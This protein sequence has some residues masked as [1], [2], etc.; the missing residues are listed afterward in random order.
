MMSSQS[1]VTD[2]PTTPPPSPAPA[3]PDAPMQQLLLTM[4]AV[5]AFV[6]RHEDTPGF[7][8]KGV[9]DPNR[10]Q[11]RALKDEYI[12]L[13]AAYNSASSA[14]MFGSPIAA[15]AHAAASDGGG[16]RGG[17]SA[18]KKRKVDK[19]SPP[20]SKCTVESN[21]MHPVYFADLLGDGH[22]DGELLRTTHLASVNYRDFMLAVGKGGV[23]AVL[24]DAVNMM[25]HNLRPLK[26]ID[27]GKFQQRLEL[28]MACLKGLTPAQA[29]TVLGVIPGVHTTGEA[30]GGG[31]QLD[32][33]IGP[34]VDEILQSTTGKDVAPFVGVHSP[35]LYHVLATLLGEID[36]MLTSF[37]F[38][39]PRSNAKAVCTHL[40][41]ALDYARE[42]SMAATPDVDGSAFAMLLSKKKGYGKG[43][44]YV[45]WIEQ[46]LPYDEHAQAYL[47]VTGN[48][49]YVFVV[50]DDASY[51]SCCAHKAFLYMKDD[52]VKVEFIK[53]K[54]VSL[55]GKFAKAKATK[56]AAGASAAAN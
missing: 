1:H 39:F 26:S 55:L 37:G 6:K 48:S 34:K 43:K 45:T 7:V 47:S 19:P 53:D 28:M 30:G 22:E 24:N 51:D 54:A 2:A 52:T 25:H 13:L 41:L 32:S 44:T 35:V 38:Q 33:S 14:G 50:D 10:L 9:V 4:A 40:Q 18:L 3:N 49:I 16:A 17:G 23:H 36:A 46:V 31:T 8:G 15:P 56:A 11:T 5:E 21:S 12:G 42:L 20:R 27:D 29:A